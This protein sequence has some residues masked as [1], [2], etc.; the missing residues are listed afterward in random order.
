MLDV[1]VSSMLIHWNIKLWHS[2]RSHYTD[3]RPTSHSSTSIM[4]STKQK[5]SY[6]HFSSLWYDPAGV[7]THDL[8]H[9]SQM[10]Y[11]CATTAVSLNTSNSVWKLPSDHLMLCYWHFPVYY[12]ECK[13]IEHTYIIILSS[14]KL[15]YY[16]L[17]KYWLWKNDILWMKSRSYKCGIQ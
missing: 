15:V 1:T 16:R 5:S 2:N 17:Y 9:A 4:L 8:P 7:R 10:L 12:V 3:T 14:S 11:H 13:Q 6:Y